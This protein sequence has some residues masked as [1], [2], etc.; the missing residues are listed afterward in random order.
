MKGIVHRAGK[1]CPGRRRFKDNQV[2][3]KSIILTR[4]RSASA[5]ALRLL[6][7]LAMTLAAIGCGS[8]PGATGWLGLN[9]NLGHAND[10]GQWPSAKTTPADRTIYFDLVRDCGVGLIRD[11]YMN[12]GVIQPAP[13]GAY[14]FS[15]SD[16]LIRRA[17]EAGVDVLVVFRGIPRWAA[18]VPGDLSIDWGV[19]ARAQ[20][21]AFIAF[22]KKYVERYDGDGIEDMPGLRRP[23]SAYEFMNEVE[24]IA[25]A[26][27]A[28]WLRLFHQAAKQAHPR[29]T[30]L[31]AGLRSPGVRIFDQ[32]TGD[33]ETYFG[34]LL[35]EPELAGP[36]FPYF[37]VVSFHNYPS[38]YPGRKEFDEAIAYLRSTMTRHNLTL[39]MWLT[40]YGHN[41]GAQ[42]ESR[43]ADNI[44][45]WALRARALGVD[46]V[47]L[48]CLYDYRRPGGS[49][50]GENLGLV[51]EAPSGSIPPKKPAFQAFRTLGE[52]IRERPNVTF[53]A[54][55]LYLL[56][57]TGDPVYAVW[58]EETYDVSQTLIAGW[59][60]VRL[61][62]GKIEIRQGTQIKPTSTPL[63]LLKTNSP[64]L[65]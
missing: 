49:P 3:A 12:W 35:A 47:Y 59:W 50:L 48:Y 63:F 9:T 1:H 31:C 29:A 4:L 56:T 55:G 7:G 10:D 33:Y 21:A 43:Q 24:G 14:D 58:K 23:V 2:T 20:T 16:N 57:G 18:A 34:R 52:Q 19:P 22:V 13:Q 60:Q 11:S 42:E 6:P 45:K 39:P 37:D 54:D 62:S 15:Q 17:Q 61:P 30:V 44:V 41:S 8:T 28:Y 51:R 25:T 32:P 26:E 36:R 64:F 53:R 38:N 46:R 27:Y 5:D 65:K 40:E